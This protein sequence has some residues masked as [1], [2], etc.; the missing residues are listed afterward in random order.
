MRVNTLEVRREHTQVYQ[1]RVPGA[2][3]LRECAAKPL[4]PAVEHRVYVHVSQRDRDHL[5]CELLVDAKVLEMHRHLAR[6]VPDEQVLAQAASLVDPPLQIL[7]AISQP[8][9]VLD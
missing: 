8:A 7:C 4:Q 3:R 2:K 5:N 6:L 1:K 9:L